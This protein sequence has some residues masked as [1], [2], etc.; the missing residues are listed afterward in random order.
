M[1]T[2]DNEAVVD[3]AETGVELDPSTGQE[4]V[5]VPIRESDVFYDAAHHMMT[6][7]AAVGWDDR[8]WT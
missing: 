2:S 1:T 6:R 3:D 8:L 7:E 5:S 4:L